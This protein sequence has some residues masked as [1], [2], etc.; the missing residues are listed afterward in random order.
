[1]SQMMTSDGEAVH[2]LHLSLQLPAISLQLAARLDPAFILWPGAC[3]LAQEN[4][5]AYLSTQ[6]M[7][8]ITLISLLI[9][10]SSS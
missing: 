10:S 6:H 8:S 5:P 1:M 7:L 4:I 2:D 9:N 3:K